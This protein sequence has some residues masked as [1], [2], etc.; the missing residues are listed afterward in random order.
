MLAGVDAQGMPRRL[1]LPL[2]TALALLLVAAPATFAAPAASSSPSARAAAEDDPAFECADDELAVEEED[3]TITCTGD[4]FSG[5][6]TGDDSGDWA[7][8]DDISGLC[9]DWADDDF[10]DDEEW[11]DDD[12]DDASA[13]VAEDDC[14]DDAD[15]GVAPQLRA[16]RATV[17]GQGGRVR[18]TVAYTLDAPGQVA[19]K[20]ERTEVGTSSGKRCVVPAAKPAGT[21]A[22]AARHA[23][24]HGK[25]CTR[26]TALRGTLLTDGDEGANTLELRRWKGQRIAPGSY[27]LTA[28][29]KV[30]GSKVTATTF[31]LAPRAGA[32]R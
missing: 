17:A 23:R 8:D 25:S 26:T 9:D 3:G 12:S 5:D 15:A 10:A 7:D 11:S 14:S 4:A 16:L 6:E 28:A 32:A 29:P 27:R 2:L 30:A 13:A 20:L 19:L 1:L 22:P 21:T 18:V 24:R 31:K